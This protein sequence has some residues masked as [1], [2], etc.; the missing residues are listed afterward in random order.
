MPATDTIYLPALH[1]VTEDLQTTETLTA[2]SVAIY[3]M[4]IAVASLVWGPL[5]GEAHTAAAAARCQ[6]DWVHQEHA[7]EQ[8][9][10]IHGQ[11]APVVTPVLFLQIGLGAGPPTGCAPPPSWQL[12]SCASSSPP[13][14]CC[15]CSG[16][17][18]GVQ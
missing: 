3:M 10:P 2:A 17:S 16:H 15:W 18:K 13:S 8:T 11:Q 9:A 7:R 5:S 4:A 6:A 12:P 1:R 14:Q